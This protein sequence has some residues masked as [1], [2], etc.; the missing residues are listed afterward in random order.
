M[1]RLNCFLSLSPLQCPPCRGFTPTLVETYTKL[2]EA[3]KNFEVVFVSS[4]RS[5][6]SYNDYFST[7]PWLAIPYGNT[8]NTEIAKYFGVQ[9]EWDVRTLVSLEKRV[10]GKK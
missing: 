8:R 3:G 2:K 5:E 1:L 4:D 10:K 9:G 7:M 6:E